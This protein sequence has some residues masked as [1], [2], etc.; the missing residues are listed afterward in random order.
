M[1]TF[2]KTFDKVIAEKIELKGF[3]YITETVNRETVYVF[4]LTEE[5]SALIDALDCGADM[6]YGNK[7]VF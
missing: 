5:L 4:E 6:L 1:T 2:A 3:P 7:L